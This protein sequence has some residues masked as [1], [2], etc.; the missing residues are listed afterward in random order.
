MCF[1]PAAVHGQGHRGAP[2]G[3][4]K[5]AANAPAPAPVPDTPDAPATEL[6]SGPAPRL[7]AFGMWLDD[8][9]LA[10]PRSIWISAGVTRWG[11]PIATGVEAP[12]INAAVGLRPRVQLSFAMS[13]SRA[14]F[15]DAEDD[16]AA[17]LGS[18]YSGAK[19]VLRDPLR[20]SVGLSVS[21]TLEVL[22]ADAVSDGSSRVAMVLPIS[23]E[24]GRGL[25]R[26]YGSVGYYTRGATF[27]SVAVE[28]HVS[29]MVALTGAFMQSWSTA[30]PED[31]EAYGLKRHRT[32]V[33]GGFTAFLSPRVAVYASL[34][35]TISG[36]EFDSARYVFGGGMAIGFNMPRRVPQRPPK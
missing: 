27:A 32:D 18:V 33:A 14:W 2:P 3:Q 17:G 25:T 12:S 26:A 16:V 19:L 10:P 28:R 1:V 9:T 29:P 8:A 11:S 22:S 34:G 30:D 35:R 5:K 23:F 4:L 7:R 21:P 31:A 20:H 24:F 13:G 36:L 15:H 6:V